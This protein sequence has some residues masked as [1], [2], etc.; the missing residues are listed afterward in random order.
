MECAPLWFRSMFTGKSDFARLEAFEMLVWR[1]MEKVKWTG[2]K[3]NEEVLHLVNESRKIIPTIR[4]R[5]RK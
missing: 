4:R 1:R 3:T 5:I 2:E